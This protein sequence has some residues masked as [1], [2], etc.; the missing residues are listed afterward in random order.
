MKVIDRELIKHLD[1]LTIIIVLALFTIGIISIASI[2]ASPFSGDEQT[3]SDFM[4]KLNFE[5][6]ERQL[7]NFAV[8][9]AV[10]VIVVVLDYHFYEKLANIMYAGIVFLLLLLVLVGKTSRGVAGWFVLSSINR[11]IQP[12][13]LCKVVLIIMFAK[14][15]SKSIEKHGKLKGIK[16]IGL[17]LAICALPTALVLWQPDFGTAFVFICIL[18]FM[19]FVSGIS[20]KYIVPTL[21]VAMLLAPLLY[22]FV[23]NPEQQDRIRVF[24]DPEADPLGAGYNVIQSKLSIGSGQLTGKGFFTAGTLAQLKY[25][26]ERHTDFIFSG[27]VEGIGFI[28]GTIIILLYFI[29][30]FRWLYNAYISGDTFGMCIIVGCAAMILAHVFENIGMTIGLM[31]VTGIPLPFISYGGSN[32]LTSMIAVGLVVNVYMRRPIGRSLA[33]RRRR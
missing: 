9:I 16:D 26:P 23:L 33:D 8:A 3:I 25:V 5:Y 28:G 20:W 31:P 13:E 7:V 4:Q 30:I 19:L 24:L 14:I 10:F 32:L 18:V 17:I 21:I 29:L 27:I 22:L 11:A 12:A 15:I 1:W 2:M 6:V